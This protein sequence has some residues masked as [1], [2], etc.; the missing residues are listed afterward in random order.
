MKQQNIKNLLCLHWQLAKDG[1]K[2][3][4]QMLA[5]TLLERT[6][7]V[8]GKDNTESTV[9][10]RQ[11]GKQA[12]RQADMRTPFAGCGDCGLCLK[13]RLALYMDYESALET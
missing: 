4:I 3:V 1:E 2:K 9:E 13:G 8:N 10:G 11:A 12:G 5:N 7:P 6:G